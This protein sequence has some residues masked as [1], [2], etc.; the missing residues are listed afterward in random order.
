MKEKVWDV[1]VVGAG[2]AGSVASKEIARNGFRVLILEKKKIV[3]VPNHCGEGITDEVLK[4]LGYDDKKS[5]ILREVKGGRLIFPNDTTI[6]FPKRGFCID[7]PKFDQELAQEAISKGAELLTQTRVEYVKRKKD[8][9]RVWTTRGNYLSRYL[10]AADGA[11]S[12]IGR[13]LG[14]YHEYID[15]VQYKFPPMERFRDDYLLFYHYEDFYPGYAWVFYRGIETTIGVGSVGK[16][17]RK[18][19][20]FLR[21]LK[22]DPEK[23]IAVQGG[24]IPFDRYPVRIALPG[25]LFCGDAG[26]FLFPFTKGGVRG[27]VFSG[28]RAGEVVSLALKENDP[29]L[30]YE[31]PERVKVFPSRSRLHLLIPQTFF[32]LNN[33]MVN[34]LGEIMDKKEYYRLPLLKGLRV[35]LKNPKPKNLY[36]IGIGFAVQR[37]Y[38]RREEFSW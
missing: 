37:F 1:I 30:L 5:W 35:F 28:K 25:V 2:P 20:K 7:R 16:V 34:V 8:L 6:Y 14:L 11:N 17:R 33:E 15:A 26:G 4:E 22:I 29:S 27:A 13:C 36:G 10:I 18:L 19:E 12:T 3:G 32:S 31:Y 21:F 24:R 38:K 23:R 9:W